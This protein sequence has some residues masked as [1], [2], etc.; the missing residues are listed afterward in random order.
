[1][2]RYIVFGGTA[3]RGGWLDYLG[4]AN[5]IEQAC[6]LPSFI[7]MPITWWHVVDTLTGINNGEI[8]VDDVSESGNKR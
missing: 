4:S 6:E 7:R 2:K 1:M 5:T 3:K 8:V